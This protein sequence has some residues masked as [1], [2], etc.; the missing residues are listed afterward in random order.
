MAHGIGNLP[1]D[2]IDRGDFNDAPLQAAGFGIND[3]QHGSL[4]S[5]TISVMELVG[6]AN[7]RG[8]GERALFLFRLPR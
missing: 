3:A 4:Q 6:L 5:K 2:Y 1:V 7:R 8:G